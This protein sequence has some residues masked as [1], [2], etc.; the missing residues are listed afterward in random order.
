MFAGSCSSLLLQLV[1]SVAGSAFCW[2]IG[3]C[4]GNCHRFLSWRQINLHSD[5]NVALKLFNIDTF[6]QQ[7]LIFICIIVFYEDS[8]NSYVSTLVSIP[9]S[10]YLLVILAL[11]SSYICLYFSPFLL[12]SLLFFASF[13]IS[14]SVFL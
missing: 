5:K 6:W 7:N 1:A 8:F 3:S 2:P 9:S 4:K 14:V 10:F 11:S 13:Y 12:P